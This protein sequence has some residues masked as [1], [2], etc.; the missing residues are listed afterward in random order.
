MTATN[1]SHSV[2]AARLVLALICAAHASA[3]DAGPRVE[4][5]SASQSDV[6]IRG[7]VGERIDRNWRG[8][9]MH[10][11]EGA[12]LE[13]FRSRG[14][15]SQAW[16][17]EHVGKWLSAASMACGYSRDEALLAKLKRVAHGLMAAQTADGYLGTYVAKD[18]WTSW[19]VWVHKYNLLGLLDYHAATGDAAALSA[20]RRAGD[21]LCRTFGPDRADIL[22]AGEHMGM[23]PASVLQPMVRLYERTGEQRYLEFAQYVAAS[24]DRPGGP[25]IVGGLLSHG[26]VR[27]VGNAKGYEMIS[28]IIGLLRL[29]RLDGDPRVL[30][31]ACIAAGDITNNLAYVTGGATYGEFFRE[32]G[33]LPN[34]G[35]VAE[36]CVTMSLVQLYG[37]LLERTGRAEYGNALERLLYNH[38]LACQHPT[39]ESICYYTPLWGHKFYMNFLGCCISS[40]PRAIAMVP[41]LYYLRTRDCAVVN[42]LGASEWRTRLPDGESLH[43]VQIGDYPFS[44][45]ITLRAST[46]SSN[47]LPLRIRIPEGAGS[48]RAL[49]DGAAYDG[50]IRPGA[51]FDVPSRAG[52]RVIELDLEFRWSIIKGTGANDGLFALRRG[53]VIFAYD[54]SL[55][56]TAGK[57]DRIAF[58]AEVSKLAPRLFRHD[59]RWMVEVKGYAQSPEGTWLPKTIRLLPYADA[60]VDDYFSV[61]LRDRS[62]EDRQVFSLFT[63]AHET[64]S[65][66]GRHRGSIADNSPATF[67]ST[68]D[69]TRAEIDWFEVDSGWH[70]KYNV[71]VFRHGRS[72]AGGGWFDTS[73]G[74]PRVLLKSWHDYR[75]VATID[76]YPDTT[77]TS[78]G[79]L[80]DGQAFRVV[81]PKDKREPAFRVRICGAP[82]CGND[83]SQNFASCSEIQVFYDPDL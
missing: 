24:L 78:P 55:N 53:P 43:V 15:R 82:A 80:A 46:T 20:C 81:I 16:A 69:G 76:D 12:L 65:R 17:G 71:I 59:G 77:A 29:S 54:Y 42:L 35:H 27:K 57:P 14:T 79:A 49:I 67:T 23:A 60:G 74:K 19:D 41:S 33:I 3:A 47:G 7:Y 56:R 83:A 51:F 4:M 13:P 21:L 75:E 5:S 48:P 64:A 9:L 52:E 28:C 22:K 1:R 6:A 58:E 38:L 36:T 2:V 62:R 39:G 25:R 72:L 70:T 8:I 31:A 73:R 10:K 44:D 30:D 32:P 45:K 68:D 40:G 18:R 61:W 11:D 26:T 50:S 63:Q 66:T 37:E 34:V